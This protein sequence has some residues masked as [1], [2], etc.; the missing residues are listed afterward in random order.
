MGKPAWI[1]HADGPVSR[2]HYNEQ[3]IDRG[4]A[5]L[6]WGD[7]ASLDPDDYDHESS[8]AQREIRKLSEIIEDDQLAVTFYNPLSRITIG[9]AESVCII[10]ATDSALQE[11]IEVEPYGSADINTD[12]Y[13][14]IFKAVK[15][16]KETTVEV[17]PTDAPPL[18]DSDLHPPHWSACNWNQIDEEIVEAAYR[19]EPIPYV[20]SSL[21]PTQV[22][23]C[24]E[25]YLRSMFPSFR[26]TSTL[27]GEQKD[28]DVIGHVGP[29][30]GP[31]LIAEM[32]GGS[33]SKVEDRI[34]RLNKY[35]DR[36]DHLYLFAP[37]DSRPGS[38]PDAIDFVA[39]EDVFDHLDSNQRTESML[40]E[41][42]MHSE[43]Q[44][45]R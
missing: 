43:E 35:R 12:E 13:K 7:I 44:V 29:N 5:M 36:A 22:E 24:A 42:L 2:K 40:S 9:K 25:E 21:T 8:K 23:V 6:H 17:S 4:Y 37:S 3:A 39:L 16:D 11:H 32:T 18:F 45:E 1:N 38:V 10:P 20:A 34:D 30:H 19:G 15:F 28:V 27:G 41:M 14:W 26:R 31:V 33:T